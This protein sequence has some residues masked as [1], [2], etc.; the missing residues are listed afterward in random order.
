MRPHR[1]PGVRVHV[2]RRYDGFDIHETRTP[3]QV[4]AERALVDAAAWSSTPRRACGIL[5]A[6]VQQQL[7]TATRLRSELIGAGFVRHRKVLLAVLGDIEGGARSLAEVDLG[8][9]ARKAGLPPPRRQAVRTDSGG[10][11]RYLDADFGAFSVEVDGAVHLLPLTYWNDMSRQ[12]DIVIGSGRPI[13]R[14]STIAL[15]TDRAAVA[16]QLAAA[17]RRFSGC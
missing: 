9:I 12:N 13:L 15:R 3:P 8:I 2:S 11:R 4:R 7:T 17:A 1:L 6:G 14:F 10:R 16:R 5:A